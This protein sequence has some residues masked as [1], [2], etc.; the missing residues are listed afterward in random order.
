MEK[1]SS[2]GANT[3]TSAELGLLCFALFACCFAWCLRLVE[4][5]K[6]R[7]VW[8]SATCSCSGGGRSTV[9]VLS[10]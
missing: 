3:G 8:A 6:T 7:G 1:G 10:D 5:L 4:W 9:V 2:F